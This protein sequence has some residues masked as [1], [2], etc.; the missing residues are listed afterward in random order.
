MTRTAGRTSPRR[1]AAASLIGTAVEWYDYFIFGTASALVFGTLFFPSDDPLAGR[2]ASFAVFGVGFF[3]RPLGGFF[4]GHI[5]DRFGRK[6]ALV[7]TLLI[8]GIATTLIGLLPTADTIGVWAPIL[9]V[10]LR[11]LQGF[12]VGGEWG[13]ASLIAI[14]SAPEGKRGRYGTFPQMG[15]AIGVVMSTGVFALVTQLPEETFMS[16]GWRLPFLLSL[17][18][19]VV[20]L[21]IRHGINETDAYEQAK[22]QEKIVKVPFVEVFRKHTRSLLLAMGMRVSENML[23]YI[24]LTFAVSYAVSNL[25]V[26]REQILIS[27]TIAALLAVPVIWFAGVA[28]DN[29]G[30]RKVFI[31]GATFAFVIAFPFFW[32]LETGQVGWIILAI[33]AMYAVAVG[34]Q[35]SVEP[36]FFA[37]L[38]GSTVRYSGMSIGYQL[39]S[40][41]VGGFTPLIATAL[42][43]AGGGSWPV[44][45]YIMGG[46]VVTIV[47][48]LLAIETF[49]SDISATTGPEVP[50]A[51]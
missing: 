38:F 32:L 37:E 27:T 46:A 19:V 49:R 48:A 1:A 35:I 12:G 51:S 45:L 3:A 22:E 7:A 43:A 36:A 16:W 44:A 5:G 39:T 28:S 23:G 18:L 30:R 2:L 26:D 14:E 31:F 42:V 4:F 9:L 24:V 47:S 50:A 34:V 21:L 10:V 33:V 11:L 17:V 15:N 6:A 41:I 8:M 13:G 40:A 20:G 29:I 25:G